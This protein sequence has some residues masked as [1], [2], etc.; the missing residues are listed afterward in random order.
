MYGFGLS[1]MSG[2][3][4]KHLVFKNPLR[5]SVSLD[6]LISFSLQRHKWSEWDENRIE[7]KST[8]KNLNEQFLARRMFLGTYQ[9]KTQ[10]L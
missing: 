1:G 5:A 7:K 2:E 4:M 3:V 8:L 6:T 9:M 10:L